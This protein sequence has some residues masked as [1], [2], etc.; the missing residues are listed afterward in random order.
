MIDVSNVVYYGALALFAVFVVSQALAM[1][2][3]AFDR[4]SDRKR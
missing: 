3:T 4:I 1:L 2:D